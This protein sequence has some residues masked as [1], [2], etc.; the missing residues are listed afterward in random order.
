MQ[1]SRKR[2]RTVPVVVQTSAKRPIDKSLI[3]VNQAVNNT[4][5][6]TSLVTA[7]YP[8]TITGIR[9]SITFR[10]PI[11]GIANEGGWALIR[12]KDGVP[13]NTMS[14]T[15]A[16]TFLEPEQ[17]VIAFGRWAVQDADIATSNGPSI[18]K[19]EG[20]TKSMRKLMGG[21]QIYFSVNGTNAAAST[22]CNATIQFFAKT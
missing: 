6:N 18:D 17:E 13:P 19:I 21:D 20:T 9:W 11:G 16:A 22:V 15:N 5:S 3:N 7:T 2:Q 4:Q 14:F 1:R 8:S 10:A 12:V